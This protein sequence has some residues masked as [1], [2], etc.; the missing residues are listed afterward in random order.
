MNPMTP[1]KTNMKKDLSQIKQDARDEKR[2]MVELADHNAYSAPCGEDNPLYRY[3]MKTKTAKLKVDKDG[4]VSLLRCDKGHS[5]NTRFVCAGAYCE[6]QG[7]GNFLPVEF[8]I[9]EQQ[10]IAAQEAK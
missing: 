1:T 6:C 2:D 7:C 8:C 5:G 9:A 10:R 3:Q 4:Y